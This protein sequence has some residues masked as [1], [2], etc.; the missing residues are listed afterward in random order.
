M[1]FNFGE[2]NNVPE[3]DLQY[4]YELHDNVLIDLIK[5]SR[6][7]VVKNEEQVV[8]T[9]LGYM[10]GFMEAP[11]HYVSGVLTGTAGSGKSHAKN[12]V[13]KVF[14]DEYLYEAT[15]GSEKSLIYDD[16]WEDA[17]IAALDEL[18]KIPEETIEILKSL[19]GG[20]DEEFRYKVTSGGEGADRGA[21][22][23]VRSAMPFW[24]LYAQNEPD[25]E[26]WDRLLKIPIHE[27]KE[28]NEAVLATQWDHT[29]IAFGDSEHDYMFDFADGR[30]ALTDHI[31]EMPKNARVKIPAGEEEFGWDANEHAKHIFDTKRSETNRVGGMIAN[32][33]RASTLVNYKNREKK[34]MHIPNEGV[35]DVYITEPQD[36]WNVLATRDVL[37]ATTHELDR[38][39]KALC[40]SIQ[41][42]GGT[43]SRA[44][45]QDMQEY[46]RKTNAS[47]VKRHQ[48]EQMLEDLIQNYLVEKHERHGE[49]NLYE[50]KGWQALGS[51]EINEE[52]KRVFDGCVDPFTGEDA[53]ESARRIN[54][55]IEPTI[56]DFQS[57]TD[58]SSDSDSGQATLSGTPDTEIELDEEEEAVREHLHRSLDGVTVD[59]L[60]EREPSLYQM[61][62]IVPL[63]EDH[64]DDVDIE[65]T[66]FDPAHELWAG[67][68]YAEDKREVEHTI[69]D[70]IKRLNE[71]KGVFKTEVTKKVSG[72]PESMKC[73]VLSEDQL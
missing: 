57:E 73:S 63:D 20:E 58:V 36:V 17:Y 12:Q 5:Y 69:H 62:G 25:F 9:F 44:T 67:K 59:N 54:K 43:D 33:V 3:R 24:F 71:E 18:Q 23:I 10:T 15:Q 19:H 65:G 1:D 51:F 11:G 4:D 28:K 72:Q 56:T 7:S 34:Q 41:E 8:L 6:S 49:A 66:I 2:N 13:D 48:I 26:M 64:D 61:L 47:F 35:K 21:D 40:L 70:L 55:E 45:I 42:A 39:K 14:P 27:S 37:L 16:T 53:I 29:M 52:F 22:E 46:L 50:F 30:D 68:R 32:L 31:R 60:T 38:K